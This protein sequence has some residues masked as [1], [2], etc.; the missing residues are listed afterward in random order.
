MS[1]D[2]GW[3]EA[4]GFAA[5]LFLGY[6]FLKALTEEQCPSCGRSAPKNEPRCPHCGFWRGGGQL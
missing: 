4:L 6:A 1:E 3:R 5:A 2:D